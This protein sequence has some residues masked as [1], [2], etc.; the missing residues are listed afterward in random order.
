[1]KISFVFAVLFVDS[2]YLFEIYVLELL[3][4]AQY[5]NVCDFFSIKSDAIIQGDLKHSNFT[6]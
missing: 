5:S 1:M 4:I 2:M 3:H 6:K